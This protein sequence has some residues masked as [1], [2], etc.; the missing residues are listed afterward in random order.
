[1][2]GSNDAKEFNWDGVQADGDSFEKDYLAMIEA[3]K[4]LPSSP[5]IYLLSPPPL[6]PPSE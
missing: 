2:L 3:L 4:A 6:Y 1:M 5:K